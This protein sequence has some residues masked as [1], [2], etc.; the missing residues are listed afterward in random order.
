MDHAVV[1]GGAGVVSTEKVVV[2][3][4]DVIMGFVGG[5]DVVGALEEPCGLGAGEDDVVRSGESGG[6]DEG[7][8]RLRMLAT[9]S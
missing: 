8:P 9:C 5:D 4:E 1:P 6:N 7:T 2:G 3:V